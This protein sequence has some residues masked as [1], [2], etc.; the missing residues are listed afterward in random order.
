MDGVDEKTGKPENA[1]QKII[2][3]NKPEVW[4][5]LPVPEKAL[6]EVNETEETKA[7]DGAEE[8]HRPGRKSFQDEEDRCQGDTVS[9]D[10]GKISNRAAD[11]LSN[12]P[13]KVVEEI[14]SEILCTKNMIDQ[15]RGK[16]YSISLFMNL[17]SCM[18]VICQVFLKDFQTAEARQNFFAREDSGSKGIRDTFK[19]MIKEHIRDEICLNGQ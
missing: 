13:T 8:R 5:D 7:A 3:G 6:V 15:V 19:P 18:V 2:E 9:D 16:A 4:G 12:C 17:V 11:S 1:V 14:F 10:G